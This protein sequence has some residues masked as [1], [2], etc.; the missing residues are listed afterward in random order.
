MW[1]VIGDSTKVLHGECGGQG[2]DLKE[3]LECCPEGTLLERGWWVRAARLAGGTLQ[4]LSGGAVSVP[5]TS[6]WGSRTYLG[7]L[8][9]V[10]HAE[11]PREVIMRGELAP[12][13]LK[14]NQPFRGMESAGWLT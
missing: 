14:P 12:L 6:V 1:T 4:Q 13:Q 9:T 3:R 8:L 5:S 2:H 7:L 11:T 10:G